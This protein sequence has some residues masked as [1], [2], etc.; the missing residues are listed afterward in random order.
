MIVVKTI[1]IDGNYE[2]N[3]IWGSVDPISSELVLY[4]KEQSEIIEQSYLEKRDTVYL[5][6]F[7][8]VNIT[9][10]DG[11]P[12]QQT[13]SGYRSVFREMVIDDNEEIVK[14]VEYNNNYKAW[15][16]STTKTTHIGFLVD[17]S[18]SMTCIYKNVV[19]QAIEEFLETQKKEIEH[20]IKFYGATFSNNINYLFNGTDLKLDNNIRDTFYKIIPSGGTAYYD[21]VMDIIG[22]IEQKY[23]INDEVIICIVTDG[24]DNSSTKVNLGQMKNKILSKK[25]NSWNIV[26]IGTNNLDTNSISDTYGIGQNASINTG[27]NI[28][29][30]KSAFIGISNGISR[31]RSGIDT[32]ISFNN[33]ERNASI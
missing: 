20:N 2:N 13:G 9:F 3:V 22:N 28:D 29:N 12:Y 24:F 6:I 11:K 5:D 30:Y 4:N 32:E 16:L 19:E 10:N 1:K 23:N 15:Y 17:T 21:S 33:F 8:G 14:E 18:G 27:N 7:N 26:M 31:V 25:L